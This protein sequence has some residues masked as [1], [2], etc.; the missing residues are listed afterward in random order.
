MRS[1]IFLLVASLIS[2]Y[3]CFY[4][5]YPKASLFPKNQEQLQ[6]QLSPADDVNVGGDSTIKIDDAQVGIDFRYKLSHKSNLAH[7]GVNLNFQLNEK[8]PYVNF[9]RFSAITFVIKCT[10]RNTL[11]LG[12]ST[13]DEKVTVRG[14][15]LTYRTATTLFKCE[16]QWA[17]VTV[18]L[19]RLEVPAWW[20][21]MFKLD[22]AD[23][24]YSLE[25]VLQI[26]LLSSSDSPFDLES[27]V[28]ISQITLQG[29][30]VHII[31]IYFIALLACWII[32]LIGYFRVAA[33][34]IEV[35][36]S[37]KKQLVGYQQ[38]TMEPLRDREKN[39]IL[40]HMSTHYADPDIEIE[41]MSK[42][43]GISRSKINEILKAE[44]GLTFT[45]YLNKLR[46]TEAARLLT[47]MSDANITE[48]VYKVGYKNISYFNKLFK[49]EFLCTPKHYKLK[50]QTQ[51]TRSEPA[52][53][54]E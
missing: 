36:A 24:D 34:E 46:I 38:L 49:E 22:V 11:F 1:F 20:L 44:V 15:P 12:I 2:G 19:R 5:A 8:Q 48:I 27:Q 53:R 33:K 37:N 4:F 16:D 18:D 7:A 52:P 26:S 31:Y 30:R 10:P 40:L 51:P 21:H 28:K 32:F 47:E 35:R 13:F 14:T 54:S 23:D 39:A 42:E 50:V 17:P 25:K 43:L 29:E 41:Q 6:W 3:V 45:A 9:E